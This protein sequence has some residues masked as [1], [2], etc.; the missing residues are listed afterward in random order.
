MI[1]WARLRTVAAPH[2]PE[3]EVSAPLAGGSGD[4]VDFPKQ[5]E[6]LVDKAPTD[7]CHNHRRCKVFDYHAYHG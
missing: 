2:L 5:F 1:P 3:T 7:G 4:C 6:E